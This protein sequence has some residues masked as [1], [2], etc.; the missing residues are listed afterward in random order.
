VEQGKARALPLDP[1]KGV[2]FEIRSLG[3]GMEEGPTSK[4]KPLSRPLLDTQT[5]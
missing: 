5:I 3:L 1:I 2:A 4:L